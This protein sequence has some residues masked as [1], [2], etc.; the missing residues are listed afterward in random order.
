MRHEGS[1]LPPETY[2]PES[3]HPAAVVNNLAHS[4]SISGEPIRAKCARVHQ[5]KIT[6]C[7]ARQ[8]S[9]LAALPQIG[10]RR[11]EKGVAP[12]IDV[13]VCPVIRVH[14]VD[15][16]DVWPIRNGVAQ[17]HADE[18]VGVLKPDEALVKPAR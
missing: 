18:H 17:S 7:L 5:G 10:P 9:P 6:F 1:R 2:R 8:R 12:G 16:F 4:L 15:G 14:V 11:L 3:T 13:S